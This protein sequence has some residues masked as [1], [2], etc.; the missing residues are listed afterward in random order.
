MKNRI[1]KKCGEE[2][3]GKICRKCYLRPKYNYGG[4]ISLGHRKALRKMQKLR[5]DK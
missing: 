4:K 2:C 3:Y 1:C 5:E